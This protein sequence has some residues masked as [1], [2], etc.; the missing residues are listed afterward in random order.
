VDV[1]TVDAEYWSTRDPS[2]LTVRAEV[3]ADAP[4]ELTG[5]ARFAISHPKLG[6]VYSFGV[7]AVCHAKPQACQ[8]Q[9]VTLWVEHPF[10]GRTMFTLPV[11][12]AR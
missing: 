8:A 9:P 7:R 3:Q 6:A 1:R 4:W 2:R 12:L 11:K 5:P 10:P